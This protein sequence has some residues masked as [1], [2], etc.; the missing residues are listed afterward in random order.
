M[1]NRVTEAF[2]FLAGADAKTLEL[3]AGRGTEVSLPDRHVVC[4]EGSESAVMPLVL[5]GTVRVYKTG[6]TGREITLYRLEA[7]EG[8][9]LTAACILNR[10]HFPAH[11][12]AEGPVDAYAIPADTFRDWVSRFDI[13]RDYVF[14]LLARRLDTIIAVVEEVAFRRLDVRLV[15]HLTRAAAR[16]DDATIRT[17]HEAI[18]AELGSSREVISR[19]LKDFERAGLVVLARGSIMVNDVNGLRALG[20]RFVT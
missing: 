13:W 4:A 10:L 17:T 12:V 5:S 1:S 7:G 9:I 3:L 16:S 8:C 15:E 20:D 18:A 11:A 2:P 6:E 14:H 19:L